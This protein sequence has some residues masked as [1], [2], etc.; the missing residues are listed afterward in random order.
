MALPIFGEFMLNMSVPVFD[1]LFLSQVS[2]QAAA[3]VGAVMPW[4]S[5]AIVFFSAT[6]IAGASLA[7]QYMGKQN[8]PR[9]NLMLAGLVI[10]GVLAGLLCG[11]FFVTQANNIGQWMSLPNGMSDLAAEYLVL[12]GAGIGFMGLRMTLANICNAYGRS[13]WNTI[14]AALMLITNILGNGILV[15][16]WFGAS[17]MGVTGVALASLI[18]WALSLS[19]SLVVVLFL[20]KVKLP[21]ADALMQPSKSLKP[22][23]KI[24]VPSA[25]EPFS[26]QSFVMVM[27][28]MIV[29]LG[30]TSIT[31][32]IYALNIYVYCTMMLV[33]L[34]IAN[35]MLVTQLAGAGH[36]DRC[37]QQM[38]QG[39]R[40]GLIAVA[41]VASLIFIFHQPLL[42]IFTN[43]PEVLA[44]GLVV[45]LIHSINEPFRAIN[46]ISGNVLR[47]CGDAVFVTGNAIAVTWLFS[48]PL[49]YVMGVHFGFGLY[50]ILL[51]GVVDECLRSQINWRRWKSDKWKRKLAPD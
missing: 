40:W 48:V 25:L 18:A 49:A 30:E 19:F 22:I 35:T 32:R 15:L 1:A 5:M 26:Y 7:S 20:I 29:Q 50:A 44:L 17:P 46:I 28:L 2:D 45:C 6:G 34:G 37:H 36:F 43:N 38:R 3:S 42:G 12:A 39:L 47:G 51:A 41:I 13:Y 8:Y 21:L 16:G 11:T 14:S 27:N 10:L 31:V 9:A 4:F 23:L 24:A 33:A